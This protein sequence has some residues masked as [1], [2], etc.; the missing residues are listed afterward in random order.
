MTVTY[1]L[2]SG[3]GAIEDLDDGV[4]TYEQA[5]VA[6]QEK[7]LGD[8]VLYRRDGDRVRLVGWNALTPQ[9]RVTEILHGPAAE[10]V[11]GGG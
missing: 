9:G 11:Q 10:Q 7:Q 6:L 1:Y 4:V 8:W 5:V 3:L 2:W